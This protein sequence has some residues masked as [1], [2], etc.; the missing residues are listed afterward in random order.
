MM[1]TTAVFCRMLHAV[2]IVACFV[3]TYI[4]KNLLQKSPLK[5]TEFILSKKIDTL[6]LEKK[7]THREHILEDR[8]YVD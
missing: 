3:H 1:L 6:A 8:S 7:L 4:Y 2:V 5:R